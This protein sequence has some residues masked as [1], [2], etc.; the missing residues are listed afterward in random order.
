MNV[1][2]IRI[3]QRSARASRRSSTPVG[4][5]SIN[6]LPTLRGTP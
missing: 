5:T 1:A 3:G 6:S 2:L 4:D